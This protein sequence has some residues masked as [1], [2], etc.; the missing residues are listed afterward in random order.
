MATLVD[1]IVIKDSPFDLSPTTTTPHTFDFDLP[2]DFVQGTGT[3]KPVL[4][5]VV[6]GSLD[7]DY[8]FQIGFN[9]PQE[10]QSKSELRYEFKNVEAT[11][12]FSLHE[13]VDGSKLK[14]GSNTIY[15]RINTGKVGFSDVILWFQR[16]A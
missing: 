14:I 12:I 2:S 5:F 6:R 15:F 4:Q 13:A 1:Y 16:N 9:D 7:D 8:T 3:A 11:R 10:L